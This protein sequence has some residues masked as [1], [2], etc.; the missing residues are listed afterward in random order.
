VLSEV[1]NEHGEKATKGSCNNK[2]GNAE[3]PNATC[4]LYV[5]R[6]DQATGEWGA[7]TYIATLSR[8]DI[9]DWESANGGSLREMTARV[10]PNGRYLAFMS[11]RSLTGYDN[12][13]ANPAAGGARDEEVF[14]YNRET[15]LLACPS[16]NP[17]GARPSGVFDQENSGEGLGLVVDRP[18]TWE[19][20]WLA[21]SVPG[22]TTSEVT[23]TRYQSRYLSNSGRLFFNSADALQTLDTNGKEDVYEFEWAGEGTCGSSSGCVSLLTSGTST[24]ESAFLDASTTGDSVFLLT[25]APLLPAQDHDP[26]FDIYNAR[27]C[28]GASPCVTVSGSTSTNCVE[29]E[30]CKPPAP[31]L[32][33]FSASSTSTSG[34]VKSAG[35]LGTKAAKPAPKPLTRK[36]KLA[37]ALKSCKKLKKKSKRITC[38][39]RARKKYGA[40]K[41][42]KSK[43]RKT[44][45]RKAGK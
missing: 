3:A 13:D 9:P 19:G 18:E 1:A 20:R 41:A 5:E 6:L 21:G 12:R 37:K 2:R 24:R 16:C 8:E 44:T 42:T 31:P 28:S 38:E 43:A 4:S 11:N 10:S 25:A 17:T 35:V 29:A 15:G 40:K 14:E 45:S 33:T 26:N 32:P 30:T 22:W 34:N 27:V 36:Q 7:P 39:K 23:T